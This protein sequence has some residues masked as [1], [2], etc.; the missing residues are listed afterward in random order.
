MGDAKS[1]FWDTK[2]IILS[3]LCFLWGVVVLVLIFAGGTS[4]TCNIDL[5]KQK[6][7]AAT[8]QDNK[9]YA[10]AIEEYK[11]IIECSGINEK[12]QANLNYIIA[13]IYMDDLKDYDNALT[14]YYK[15]KS[16][17]PEKSID[18][19]I[20]RKIVAAL[21][22][23]GRSMD[24]QQEMDKI[25]DLEGKEP[26]K[27]DNSAVVAKVGQKEITIKELERVIDA[28]PDPVKKMYQKDK[29]KKMEFLGQYISRELLLNTAKRKNMDKD[30]AINDR[31]IE[32][33]KELLIQRLLDEEVEKNIKISESDIK[34]Y[35]ETHKDEF[36]EKDKDKEKI[37]KFDEVKA[38]IE[39]NVHRQKYEELYKA[40][41]VRMQTAEEVK[42]F[43]EA[44]Q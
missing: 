1:C 9:L 16:S 41:L 5:Q 33:K 20:N 32:I 29:T 27:V 18:E 15:S 24:A 26:K 28:L 13:N 37:K 11:K 17:G 31:M 25:T 42:I 10:Q 35:Y 43:N 4:K 40:L 22:R 21:E 19:E 34:L 23:L 8:L 14:H 38:Q 7:L 39:N 6:E 30:P 2:T 12:E 36:K 3:G 44:I